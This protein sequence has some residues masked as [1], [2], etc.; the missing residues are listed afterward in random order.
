MNI[1][2]TGEGPSFAEQ[3]RKMRKFQKEF[4]QTRDRAVLL[5]AKQLEKEVDEQLD[6]WQRESIWEEARQNQPEL[7][8]G[9]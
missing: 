2:V 7:F 9:G 4:Y 1:T 3:V 5:R 8:I 6:K